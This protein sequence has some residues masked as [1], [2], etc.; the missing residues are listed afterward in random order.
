MDKEFL[1][2]LES[3]AEHKEIDEKSGTANF[4][5]SFSS[6]EEGLVR[7]ESDKGSFSY[8]LKPLHELFSQATEKII[9]IDW[10]DQYYL[11]LLYVIEHAIKK[12]HEI[13]YSLTDPDVILALETLSMK[14]EAL[15]RNVIVAAIN[16]ELRLQLS[17]NSYTRHEVKMAIRK[18]LNS[19]R[20]HYKQGGLRGYLNFIMEYVP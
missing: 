18:V 19:A 5:I 6:D 15:S 17:M 13:H 4:S 10:E 3:I 1:E 20:K 11:T 8:K 7:I 16:Q 12:V 14:P 9:G 2:K